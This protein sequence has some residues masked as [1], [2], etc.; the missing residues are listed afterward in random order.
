MTDRVSL[1]AAE[2]EGFITWWKFRFPDVLIFHIPNGGARYITTA[3]NL[4]KAGVVPGIPDLYCPRYRLWIEFKRSKGGK[5]SPEQEKII[6][7]LRRV[8]DA[9]IVAH[10]SEDGSRQV[11]DFMKEKKSG[12]NKDGFSSRG[13]N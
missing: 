13:D 8:G 5:L 10:G 4:K 7:Y 1:E 11:L 9:V 12:K 3:R 2:Q 6:N